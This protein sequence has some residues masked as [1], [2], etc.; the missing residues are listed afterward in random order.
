MKDGVISVIIPI[1]NSG[2]HL[3]RCLDSII[4]QT[5]EKLE[6]ILIDDGSTDGSSRICDEY[7]H[8]DSR[9]ICI[10]QKNGGV[11]KARNIGISLAQGEY[12]HF[13]DSDDYLELDCYEYIL[14]LIREKSCEVVSFEY[15]ITYPG[16][17]VTHQLNSDQYGVCGIKEAHRRV[18][19]GVPFSW[20]KLFVRQAVGDIVFR[21]DIYRG[22]DTLFV[23]EVID[24]ADRVWFD[25]RPLYHYVQSQESAVRGKF[26]KNQLSALKLYDAYRSMYYDKYPELLGTFL[27]GMNNLLISLYF[28]MWNDI[29]EYPEEQNK[30]YKIFKTHQKELY[31]YG[32]V[33]I[34]QSIKF[35]LFSFNPNLF[36]YLHKTVFR[37]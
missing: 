8:K 37:L 6:I 2:E 4:N 12:I 29:D 5:Y 18:L 10:H 25:K 24:Q 9:I 1:Y 35:K 34:K 31:K 13:P 30:V 36:C 7:A 11:S 17:E 21:E 26:R 16:K 23:Q 27:K 33:T 19:A 32:T 20:N 28:D 22:E 3:Y 14:G 15:Y